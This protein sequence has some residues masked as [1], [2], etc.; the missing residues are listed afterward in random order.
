[1]GQP[2]GRW[3]WVISRQGFWS[4]RSGGWERP[5]S[6]SSLSPCIR[7]V[8]EEAVCPQPCCKYQST[9]LEQWLQLLQQDRQ[10]AF[11]RS[12]WINYVPPRHFF[13][14]TWSSLQVMSLPFL[15]SFK[16]SR[17]A[18]QNVFVLLCLLLVWSS[19]YCKSHV[20]TVERSASKRSSSHIPQLSDLQSRRRAKE[21]HAE[22]SRIPGAITSHPDFGPTQM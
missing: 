22:D 9:S 17:Y 15:L 5:D 1:M 19:F 16:C 7:S 4:R 3:L 13:S 14:S 18:F 6:S 20:N 11:Q 12:R 8:R 21:Q 10:E 2:L